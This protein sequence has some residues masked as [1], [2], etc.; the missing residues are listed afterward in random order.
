MILNCAFFNWPAKTDDP[1]LMG[2][3]AVACYILVAI[4]AYFALRQTKNLESTSQQIKTHR[5]WMVVTV[6]LV[7]LGINKQLDTQLLL[8]AAA[9]CI[10]TIDGWYGDRRIYQIG[11]IAVLAVSFLVLAVLSLRY[12]KNELRGNFWAIIG[13]LFLLFFIALRA[14]SFHN[15]DAMLNNNFYGFKVSWI[16]ELSGLGLLALQAILNLTAKAR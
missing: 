7:L 1:H 10:S 14:T 3:A 15:L 16:F 8:I 2:W 13:L 9:K 11:F 5:F 6:L 4:L 12:F